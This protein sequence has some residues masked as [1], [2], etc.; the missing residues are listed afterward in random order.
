MQ[1]LINVIQCEGKCHLVPGIHSKACHKVKL[2]R[3]FS[4]HPLLICKAGLPA[5]LLGLS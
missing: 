3:R 2:G 4:E 1:P 5:Y